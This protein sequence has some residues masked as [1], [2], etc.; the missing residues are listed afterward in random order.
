MSAGLQGWEIDPQGLEIGGKLLWK[1]EETRY[2]EFLLWS[3]KNIEII[4]ANPN[5]KW[6][7]VY[8]ICQILCMIILE[9][10]SVLLPKMNQQMERFYKEQKIYIFHIWFKLKQH[11]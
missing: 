1:Y 6:Y 8:Y 7:L 11:F 2:F 9:R 4:R 10:I 5:I 3:K